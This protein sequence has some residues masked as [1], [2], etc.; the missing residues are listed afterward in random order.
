MDIFHSTLFQ[1]KLLQI[2]SFFDFSPVISFTFELPV[3]KHPSYSLW[4]HCGVLH[5]A[6]TRLYL[7]HSSNCIL[8]IRCLG[9]C[10]LFS[11]WAPRPWQ[12]RTS[13]LWPYPP[14]QG[15]SDCLSNNLMFWC[16]ADNIGR[17]AD[18]QAS[19]LNKN[20]KKWESVV[21]MREFWTFSR[22][23]FRQVKLLL[24]MA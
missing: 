9:C 5:N 24:C 21:V 18:R 20:R 14:F 22:E 11:C 12:W 19:L 16:M 17:Q 10:L 3:L 15:T 8:F 4:R 7:A 13:V 23:M 6:T 1:T 2:H